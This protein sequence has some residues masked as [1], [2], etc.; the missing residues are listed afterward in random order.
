MYDAF[1]FDLSSFVRAT[2]KADIP[3]SQLYAAK[4]RAAFVR[5]C[6]FAAFNAPRS[7]GREAPLRILDRIRSLEPAPRIQRNRP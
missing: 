2:P 6:K 3:F 7:F 5:F 1:L 4:Q